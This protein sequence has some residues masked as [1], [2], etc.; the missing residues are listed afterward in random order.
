MNQ[1]AQDELI[2]K[3]T[4]LRRVHMQLTKIKN[5]LTTPIPQGGYNTERILVQETLRKTE[6][7]IAGLNGQIRATH[8]VANTT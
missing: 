2:H 6:I 4:R 5:N 8:I 7:Q 1:S 3:L